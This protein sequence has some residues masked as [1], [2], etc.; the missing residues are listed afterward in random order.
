MKV[1]LREDIER[2]GKKGD[3][4]EVSQGYARN[5]LL[6]RMLALHAD[7]VNLEAIKRRLLR[8]EKKKEEEKKVALELAQKIKDLSLTIPM[9][10]GDDDK[11]YGSVSEIEIVDALKK[12]G[13]ELDKKKVILEEPIKLLG[14]YNIPIKLS[15]DL[16]VSVRIWVVKE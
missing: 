2:L 15:L 8:E 5:F 9:K 4:V 13:I 1:V 7:E 3:V 11:L 10:A 14:V 12:E 16:S 6:P